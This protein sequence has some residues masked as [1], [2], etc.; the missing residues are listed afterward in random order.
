MD[1]CQGCQINWKSAFLHQHEQLSLLEK[2]EKYFDSV[3]G[4]LLGDEL[5]GL[6]KHFTQNESISTSRKKELLEQTR[7]LILY[8][9]PHSLFYGR[10]MTVEHELIFRDMFIKRRRRRRDAK[11]A[12]SI[13][14]NENALQSSSIKRRRRH[15]DYSPRIVK[16]RLRDAA[17]D[18]IGQ[19][20]KKLIENIVPAEANTIRN[21]PVGSI[22]Q[23]L[24]KEL[25]EISSD[26]E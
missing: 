1:Q 5:E 7:I 3:R 25:E 8:A 10:W 14:V 17:R 24:W 16:P 11:N 6:F 13:K 15:L 9:T 22:E 23:L 21:P 20:S 2:I 19:A 26:D 12:K 4:N 18:V